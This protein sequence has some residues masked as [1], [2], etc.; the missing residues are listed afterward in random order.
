MRPKGELHIRKKKVSR[1]LKRDCSIGYW[2]EEK[3][4]KETMWR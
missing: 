1:Y 3:K 4:G 2:E